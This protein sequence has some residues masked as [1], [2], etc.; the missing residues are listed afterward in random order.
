MLVQGIAW[1]DKASFQI[2][3]MRTDLLASQPEVGLDE[4]TTKVKFSEVHLLDGGVPLWLPRE[5][6]VHLKLANFLDRTSD[7]TFQNRHRYKNYRR[8]RV[9]ARIVA[10]Q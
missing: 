6:S 3:R 8:Y 10:P 4:E 7:E 5:V 9:S 1:V 2:L